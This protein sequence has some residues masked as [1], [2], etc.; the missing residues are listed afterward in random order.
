MATGN[1]KMTYEEEVEACI[2]ATDQLCG[3]YHAEGEHVPLSD[4][5]EEN[6]EGPGFTY[7]LGVEPWFS[8]DTIFCQMCDGVCDDYDN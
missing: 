6:E 3:C 4:L 2:E 7:R 8:G 5:I 1:P